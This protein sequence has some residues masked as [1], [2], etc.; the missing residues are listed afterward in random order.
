MKRLFH[1]LSLILA[2][3]FY[4]SLI[5]FAMF[6]VID[7]GTNMLYKLPKGQQGIHSRKRF[8]TRH[9]MLQSSG[10]LRATFTEPPI[11]IDHEGRQ[12]R[13]SKDMIGIQRDGL[14]EA[15]KSS[16]VEI[17]D[18]E[19]TIIKIQTPWRATL[20]KHEQ[21]LRDMNR[22]LE[23]GSRSMEQNAEHWQVRARMT[24]PF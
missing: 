12:W 21:M 23:S 2:L 18:D 4:C 15:E 7:L 19:G 20:G 16:S 8:K 17:V 13:T 24:I 1:A 14:E 22:L 11:I 9:R 5:P 10:F 3:F 6:V